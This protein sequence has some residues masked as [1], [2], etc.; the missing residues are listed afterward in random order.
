MNNFIQE[1]SQYDG[2]P[3]RHIPDHFSVDLLATGVHLRR[4]QPGERV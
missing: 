1:C 3:Y 4:A 2:L